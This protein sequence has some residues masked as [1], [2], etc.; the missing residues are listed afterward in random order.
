MKKTSPGANSASDV[1]KSCE[2]FAAAAYPH[3]RFDSGSA[4]TGSSS[5]K[6]RIRASA[7]RVVAAT[8][9][10]TARRSPS[11]ADAD[12]RGSVAV[13]SDTVAIECGTI[14]SRNAPE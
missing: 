1:A 13:A 10:P 12:S 14:T 8:W 11:A 2:V 9:R 7:V 4:T 3:T 6:G 5:A